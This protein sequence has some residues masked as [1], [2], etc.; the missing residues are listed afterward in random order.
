MHACSHTRCIVYIVCRTKMKASSAKPYKVGHIYVCV[1]NTAIE[2]ALQGFLRS[3]TS[4]MPCQIDET[5]E[6]AVLLDVPPSGC[7]REGSNCPC[8]ASAILLLSLETTAMSAAASAP[9]WRA[10]LASL[11]RSLMTC[12]WACCWWWARVQAPSSSSWCRAD[13]SAHRAE[14]A[15]RVLSTSAE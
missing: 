11:P 6:A 4:C 7:R 1:W 3:A 12:S 10:S 15:A 2:Q 5:S 9:A 14:A 13:S 8:R